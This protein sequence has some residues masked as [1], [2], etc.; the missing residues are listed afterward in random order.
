MLETVPLPICRRYGRL[1]KVIYL[2]LRMPEQ[3]GWW[4]VWSYTMPDET[5]LFSSTHSE[6][7]VVGP[8]LL[9]DDR[10]IFGT[11][12]IRPTVPP[13]AFF[14]LGIWIW[15][16]RYG[17]EWGACVR[18]A[19]VNAKEIGRWVV[20]VSPSVTRWAA[21]TIN[22][23]T[24]QSTNEKKSCCQPARLF[25]SEQAR[26]SCGKERGIHIELM[27]NLISK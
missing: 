23:N 20:A 15:L 6:L 1:E 17:G 19:M 11:S 4:P 18:A 8:C 22:E 2:R 10:P 25:D 26:Q 9:L 24:Y 5:A 21:V 3:W 12:S 27:F 14:K 16:R 7:T 13:S